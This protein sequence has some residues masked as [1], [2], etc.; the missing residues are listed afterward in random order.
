MRLIPILLLLWASS[1][2][3]Q[4]L[5]EYTFDDQ[6]NPT[7]NGG[8]LGAAQDGALVGDATFVPFGGGSAV[9]LDGDQD[10]VSPGADGD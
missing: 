2:W 7:A 1:S 6:A 3:G 5:L 4:P 8:T 10:V 9:S